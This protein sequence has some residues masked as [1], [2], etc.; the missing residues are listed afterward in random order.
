MSNYNHQDLSYFFSFILEQMIAEL[1]QDFNFKI[2]FSN[3][4]NYLHKKMQ[5]LL[6]LLLLYF[7]VNFNHFHFHLQYILYHV[8]LDL[9]Y[10]FYHD[11]LGIVFNF[12]KLLQIQKSFNLFL[13]Q[14][15]QLFSLFFQNQALD[16]C[17]LWLIFHLLEALQSQNLID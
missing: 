16:G 10:K 7:F 13:H 9:N 2:F 6:L 14:K 15:L 17:K 11:R 12:N 3:Q 8:L 5:F 4:S 1:K